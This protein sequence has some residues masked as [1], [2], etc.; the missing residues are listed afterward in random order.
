LERTRILL[1]DLPRMIREIISDTLASQDDMEVVAELPTLASLPA[2]LE[3]S[4]A[5]V[6]VLGGDDPMLAVALLQRIPHLTV[7][8]VSEEGRE[9]WLY[10][11][12]PKRVLI[13]E[14]SPRRL[15]GAIRESSRARASE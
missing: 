6:V 11:L 14:I 12:R 8:A 7:L 3:D 1:A 5:D 4:Q 10:E 13:S 2:A 15:V 9:S